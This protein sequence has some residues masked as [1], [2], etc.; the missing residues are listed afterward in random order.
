VRGRACYAY[1]ER[2]HGGPDVFGVFLK[3][4][5]AITVQSASLRLHSSCGQGKTIG[6]AVT[7]EGGA[8]FLVQ[9][10]T[11]EENDCVRFEEERDFNMASGTLEAVVVPVAGTPCEGLISVNSVFGHSYGDA[12][13]G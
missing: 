8:F 11:G 1:D 9:E 3:S 6:D 2:K 5:P 13:R 4:G 7:G 12:G 10:V